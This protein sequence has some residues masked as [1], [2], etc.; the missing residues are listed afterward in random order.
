MQ[1]G[2]RRVCIPHRQLARCPMPPHAPPH[3]RTSPP[4][5]GPVQH[6]KHRTELKSQQDK[7]LQA[8]PP[9]TLRYQQT[10]ARYSTP[11]PTSR[12]DRNE[13][14]ASQAKKQKA[15]AKHRNNAT[16]KDHSSKDP[17]DTRFHTMPFHSRTIPTHC[18][19]NCLHSSY[20][21]NFVRIC[22]SGW[23]QAQTRS[24]IPCRTTTLNSLHRTQLKPML[25]WL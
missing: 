5:D 15:R 21:H 25:Q 19:K 14:T 2:T 8:A 3:H 9:E 13:N 11:F 24:M 22:S 16:P 6:F 18:N 23:D 12:L 7:F 1:G 10:A 4:G 17:I 20:H